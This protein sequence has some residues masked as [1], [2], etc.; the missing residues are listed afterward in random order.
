MG[1]GEWKKRDATSHFYSLLFSLLACSK[2]NTNN[3]LRNFTRQWV[4]LL[5]LLLWSRKSGS[6]QWKRWKRRWTTGLL[7][8]LSPVWFDFSEKL[9]KYY[10]AVRGREWWGRG[11]SC[12][13][14]SRNVTHTQKD[15]FL[16]GGGESWKEKFV[17]SHCTM[18]LL[19]NQRGTKSWGKEEVEEKWGNSRAEKLLWANFACFNGE[20]K[21]TANIFTVAKKKKSEAVEQSAF[22]KRRE[23]I[24]QGKHE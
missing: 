13:F 12:I 22:K 5:L 17:R 21:R 16:K 4:H 6:Q 14:F 3:P 23:N 20:K 10:T 15:T 19:G 8:A 24:W 1:E 9:N 11:C 18:Q 2:P 7:H